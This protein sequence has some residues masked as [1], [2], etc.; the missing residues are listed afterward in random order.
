[1]S[2]GN[3]FER[4]FKLQAT[5]GKLVLGGKRDPEKI[6]NIF[7]A[8]IEGSV[9][10]SFS[11]EATPADVNAVINKAAAEFD[12]SSERNLDWWLAKTQE[13]AKKHLG[14]DI[15]LRERFAIP[16][17]L[18]WKSV[19]PVFDPGSLTN[20]AVVEQA[21]KALGLTVYEETDVMKYSGSEAINAPTLHFIE[22]SVRPNSD[23]MNM[24]PNQLRK[25][26]KS[27]LSL[28]GYGL[29]FA[30][31]YFAT[32]KHLDPET[33]TWFPED[34]FPDDLVALG[35]WGP[36]NRVVG[37]SRG[38]SGLRYPSGGARVAMSV[39]LALVP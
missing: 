31:Y 36:G 7:Q 6:A 13:F 19:I 33:F 28:H 22:N 34:R 17:E 23:T 8:I 12:L 11:N 3:Q 21:L 30:V 5:V 10:A 9:E 26:G 16:A 18:P 14:V 27:Y 32:D 37:F 20:R 24:S 2:S 25:T 4:L 15:N 29:A 39:P 35:Y 1:M 38:R